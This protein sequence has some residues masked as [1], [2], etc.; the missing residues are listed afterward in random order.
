MMKVREV[1]SPA[2][3]CDAS[4]SLRLVTARMRAR[5]CTAVVVMRKGEIAGIV[6]DYDIARRVVSMGPGVSEFAAETVMSSPLMTTHPDASVEAAVEIMEVN[7]VHHLPVAGDDGRLCGI[8]ALSDISVRVPKRGLRHMSR[9]D[10]MITTSKCGEH[11]RRPERR[12]PS[13]L[14]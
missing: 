2:V 3:T 12:N 1:M 7:Q 6:T 13:W 8:I 11:H 4:T 10:V 5:N 9:E 14:Y